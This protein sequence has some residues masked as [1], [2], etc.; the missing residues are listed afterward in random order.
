MTVQIEVLKEEIAALWTDLPSEKIEAFVAKVTEKYEEMA[1]TIANANDQ[2]RGTATWNWDDA[3]FED[4]ADKTSDKLVRTTDRA[5]ELSDTL[6]S[7]LEGAIRAGGDFGSVLK[8]V[9]DDLLNV[10]LKAQIIEPLMGSLFGGVGGSGSGILG[11][12]FGGMYGGAR[13]AGGSVS[14]GKIYS[15]GE[16]GPEWFAPSMAGTIIPNGRS[17]GVNNITVNQTNH[18][19]Q[20]LNPSDLAAFLPQLI[21]STKAAVADE[22]QRG[23]SF[24]RAMGKV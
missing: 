1:V 21:E 13:A 5:K 15:V 22:R 20:G 10:F 16:D 19:E 2:V 8:G 24:H 3:Q 23:G 14:P 11:S 4:V 6:K 9:A 12:L 17:G 18:F 7:G